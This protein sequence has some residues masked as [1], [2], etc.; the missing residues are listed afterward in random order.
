M[1]LCRLKEKWNCQVQGES[2]GKLPEGH[3]HQMMQDT[4]R[5]HGCEIL[6]SSSENVTPIWM[7]RRMSTFIFRHWY[8]RQAG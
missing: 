6:P 3:K 8:L 5:E 2:V 4:E 7:T 1:S